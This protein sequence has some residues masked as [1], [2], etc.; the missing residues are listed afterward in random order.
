DAPAQ[1]DSE[2]VDPAEDEDCKYRDALSRPDLP[3]ERCSQKG[4]IRFGPDAGQWND[5]GKEGCESD[6]ERGVSGRHD[7]RARPAAQEPRHFSVRRPQP[8]VLAA[9]LRHH[10][11]E[12]GETERSAEREES[13]DEPRDKNQ[14]WRANELRHDGSLEVDAGSDD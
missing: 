11:A 8:D 2:A 6:S 14:G 7:N 10:S 4:E 12:L 3:V 13:G 1:S 9:R 5:C